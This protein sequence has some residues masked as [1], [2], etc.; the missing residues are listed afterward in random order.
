MKTRIVH[1]KIWKDTWFTSLPRA[2]SLIFLYLITCETNNICGTFELP[3]RNIMF[4]TGTNSQELE[5]AKQ[6][7]IGRVIFHEGWV[8]L[9]HNG[10]YNNYVTNSKMQTAYNKELLVIP[11]K[12]SEYISKYDTSIDTS[13]H[14]PNNHKSKIINNKSIINNIYVSEEEILKISEDYTVPV[15]FVNSKLDDIRNY[16]KSTGKIYRDYP[17]TLRNWVKRDAVKIFEKQ[18][19]DPTRRVVDARSL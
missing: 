18:K 3:D 17:A 11:S 2:S 7:L 15:A 9:V 1:T 13:I 19:G 10:K 4:D 14:T 8:H 16:C 5:Q 6:D 12:V